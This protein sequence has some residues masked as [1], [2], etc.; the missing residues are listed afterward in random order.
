M[1]W[2]L[3]FVVASLNATETTGHGVDLVLADYDKRSL[4]EVRVGGRGMI[5]QFHLII[6]NLTVV[7]NLT[8]MMDLKFLN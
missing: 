8:S 3:E 2:R 4:N 6:A 7:S 1:V 5:R